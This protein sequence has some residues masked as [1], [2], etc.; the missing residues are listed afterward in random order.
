M[1]T[2]IL[3]VAELT[4]LATMLGGLMRIRSHANHLRPVRVRD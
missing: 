4:V 2:M 1:S 3:T